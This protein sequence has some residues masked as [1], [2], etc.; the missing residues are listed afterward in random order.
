MILKAGFSIV[1]I[2][3]NAS[4]NRYKFRK[5][6]LERIA[7]AP[8]S[9]ACQLER[10][11]LE[12]VVPIANDSIS[13]IEGDISLSES[14]EFLHKMPELID[15]R[16]L[17]SR[18]KNWHEMTAMQISE[19]NILLHGYGSSHMLHELAENK[20]LYSAPGPKFKNGVVYNSQ[21]EI[22]VFGLRARRIQLSDT[23]AECAVFLQILRTLSNYNFD[24]GRGLVEFIVSDVITHSIKIQPSLRRE[25]RIE[26]ASLAR[27][28]AESLVKRKLVNESL[29]NT[30][31]SW[32]DS[33]EEGAAKLKQ[34]AKAKAKTTTKRATKKTSKR[35]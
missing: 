9:Q 5:R 19:L 30:L 25:I 1:A 6:V 27:R 12:E 31:N 20:D 11:Q 21:A 24:T 17:Y 14:Y 18:F 32:A 33:L 16:I 13:K 23:S 15:K 22:A 29:I 3:A 2:S 8:H 4:A 10:F 26:I 7:V 35:R 28:W 34:S